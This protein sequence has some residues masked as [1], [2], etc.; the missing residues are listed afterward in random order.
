MSRPKILIYLLR[1]DLRFA[2]NPIFHEIIKTHQQSHTQYTHLLPLYIFPANQVEVSGFLASPSEKC[3]FPEARS[4]VGRFWRCGPHRARFMAE[5]VYDLRKALQGAGSGIEVRVGLVADVLRNVLQAYKKKDVSG[6]VVGVWMTSDEGVEERRDERDVK[7]AC[8]EAGTSFR[9]CRDEKYF[10]D[11]YVSSFLLLLLANYQSRDVPN[12]RPN[13]LPDLFTAYRKTVEPLREAPRKAL[14]VQGNLPPLPAYIPPQDSPFIAPQDLDDALRRLLAPLDQNSDLPK[15]AIT[16][17]PKATSVHPFSGGESAAHERVKHLLSNGSMTKYKDTRNGMIGEDFST[18]L[19]AYLALGCISARQVHTYLLDFE[20]GRTG[21]GRSAV[22]YGKG[23]NKG[24]GW[25][26]FELLW[27]DYMRLCARKHRHRLYRI[28][29]F[30]SHASGRGEKGKEPEWRSPGPKD[31]EA[32]K[33]LLRFLRGETGMGLIDASQRE[34]WLTGYTSNRARQNVA[35]Y[36]AKHLYLDWRLGAEWYESQLIDYD[37]SSNWGNWQYVALGDRTFNPVKQGYD[38]DAKGEYIKLWVPEL[39]KWD[40]VQG[41]FQA[42]K[43]PSEERESIGLNGVE[44]VERPLA[45]IE[46]RPGGGGSRGGSRGGGRGGKNNRGKHH[47]R[48]S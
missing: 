6:D 17:P 44:W 12:D 11:E 41:V 32:Q 3:P 16:F 43:I 21:I 5:S 33:I 22:G 38:Y 20:D 24:T 46:Y 25:T 23:E 45:R 18:K 37:S 42:W 4:Q 48:G 26:R 1:R 27:R 19:A 15:D 35:S 14:S 7:K 9:L 10:I 8:D 30:Q 36:L 40:D 34:L 29:G 39:R 31:P 47:K 13:D 2:D 28:E